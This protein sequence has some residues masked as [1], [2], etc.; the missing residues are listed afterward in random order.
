MV[1]RSNFDLPG[2]SGISVSRVTIPGNSPLNHSSSHIH[3]ECEIYINLEGDVSFEVENR[4]YPIRPGSVI[5]TRPYE[6][7]HCIAL[8][9]QMHSHYW[10]TFSGAESD[11]CLRQFYGR[12][13]GVGNLILLDAQS[14]R[15]CCQLLDR[16]TAGGPL[17]QRI[18]FLQLLAILEEGGGE[19]MPATGL[20]VDVEN[21]L[22]WMDGHLD[23][24]I[25]VAQLA[26]LGNVS[27]NTLERHFRE[28][29]GITPMA[30]LKKKRLIASMGLLRNGA[31]VSEAARS[32]G[33]AD[34]SAYIRSFRQAFTMT[35]LAYKKRFHK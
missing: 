5:I 29:L 22:S 13:K 18:C 32:S 27:I 14:L 11:P 19:E 3:K 23:E 4:I 12:E 34:D 1:E 10:I 15:R 33:F 35:P 17:Q 20:P 8:S 26:E 28:A 2:I 31:S 9:A 30:Q 24:E 25:T 21:A 16:I 6:F 7:H